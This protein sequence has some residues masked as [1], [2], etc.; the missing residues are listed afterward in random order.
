MIMKIILDDNAPLLLSL[1]WIKAIGQFGHF[2]IRKMDR[3]SRRHWI[4]DFRS[5]RSKIFHYKLIMLFYMR[6]KD[7]YIP[8]V[9]QNICIVHIVR[10]VSWRRRR[11][12]LDR[13][14]R[15]LAQRK[16][17]VYTVPTWATSPY[18]HYH[19]SAHGRVL[20]T[21]SRRCSCSDSP[22]PWP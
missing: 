8:A 19:E 9:Y 12:R 5:F 21:V 10:Y 6:V 2:T 17:N 20:E 7:S 3:A 14:C 16:W 15:T 13:V 18:L 1:R 11:F 4:E 22:R